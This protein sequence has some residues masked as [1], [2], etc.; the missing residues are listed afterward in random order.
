MSHKSHNVFNT[1]LHKFVI[2]Q[3]ERFSKQFKSLNCDECDETMGYVARRGADSN[4]K[5]CSQQCF[6]EG[7]NGVGLFNRPPANE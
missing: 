3:V 5:F 7:I 2:F 4:M 6:I 1:Y